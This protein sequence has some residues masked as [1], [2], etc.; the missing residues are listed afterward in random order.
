MNIL[1]SIKDAVFEETPAPAA[2]PAAVAAPAPYTP[3]INPPITAYPTAAVMSVD[4]EKLKELRSKVQPTA[5]P[6]V[7]FLNTSTGLSKF[8]ADEMT[9]F[10]ASA[11]TLA[12]QGVTVDQIIGQ[13]DSV[14][15]TIE[16]NR[17]LAESA[18]TK[19]HDAEVVAREN[20][21]AEIG[22]MIETKQA[23][24][25]QLIAERDTVYGEAQV[26]KSRIEEKWNGWETA[27]LTLVAEYQDLRRKITAYVPTSTGAT[28]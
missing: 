2:A 25:S 11:E 12:P 18:K 17:V 21:V 16:S 19:K 8:I 13:I 5:G 7:T 24:I 9:R 22:K 1:K 28:K 27:R 4:P 3:P 15:G 14:L 10:R 26:Q 23:E 20:R 6:L